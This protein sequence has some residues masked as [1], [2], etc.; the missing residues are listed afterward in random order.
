MVPKTLYHYW[1]S[2]CSWRVRWALELKGVKV[3]LMAVNLLKAEQHQNWFR[4][5]SPLGLVPCLEFSDG[6]VLTESV[7]ILEYLEESYPSTPLLPND[8]R[9]RAAVRALVQTI[10]SATQPM[11]NLGTLAYFESRTE[12]RPRH[13][14]YWIERGLE[15]YSALLRKQAACGRFSFGSQLSLADLCLVPQVYNALRFEVDLRK[16]PECQ[17]IYRECMALDSCQR[18]SPENQADAIV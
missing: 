1:R 4:E 17:Q 8:V 16:F 5:Y 9:S 12:L 2:S 7:A 18:A 3:D 6:S 10:V 11:Q 15:A 14:R 13:A